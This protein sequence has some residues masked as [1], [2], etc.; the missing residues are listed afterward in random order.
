MKTLLFRSALL[1]GPWLMQP[2]LQVDHEPTVPNGTPATTSTQDDPKPA[3][4]K[5]GSTMR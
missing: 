5:G 2:A 3:T 4:K 1:L